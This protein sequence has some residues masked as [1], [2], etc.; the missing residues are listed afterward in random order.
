MDDMMAELEAE[1][2][3][4]KSDMKCL[5]KVMK[6]QLSSISTVSSISTPL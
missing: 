2:A 6:S 3:E 1:L 5:K 4:A